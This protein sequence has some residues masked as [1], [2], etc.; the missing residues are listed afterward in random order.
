M[1]YNVCT[2]TVR[3]LLTLGSHMMCH[4]T[5]TLIP[6]LLTLGSHM[7]CHV[8]NTLIPM[9]LTLG[10]P[11]SSLSTMVATWNCSILMSS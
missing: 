11:G 5:Y 1:D 2:C 10:S 3:M 8:T 6:M 9:L 7:T 4:V